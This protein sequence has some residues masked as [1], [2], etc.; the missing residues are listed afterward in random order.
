MAKSNKATLTAKQKRF[1]QEYV[2]DH[3]ATKA[4]IRAGYSEKSAR[5]TACE[6]LGNVGVQEFIEELEKSL[7]KRLEDRYLISKERVLNEYARAAFSDI[8]TYYNEDGTLK[9]VTELT[10][11][12]AAALSSLE[13]DEIKLGETVIGNTRKIKLYD[14][15]RALDS[16]ARVMGYNAPED[17]NVNTSVDI[18]KY[19]AEEK[20]LLVKMSRGLNR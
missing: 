7:T 20:A 6:L 12:D 3:N 9:N 14:K 1:C 8:R 4:A 5:F 19:S 13:T 18:S 15:L 17:L 11:G 10:D 16:I 2:I